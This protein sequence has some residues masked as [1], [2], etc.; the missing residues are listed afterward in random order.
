M[1][2][3]AAPL[4]CGGACGT[5]EGEPAAVLGVRSA[6]SAARSGRP[7]A[8]RG[9]GAPVRGDTSPGSRGTPPTAAPP[10]RPRHRETPGGHTAKHSFRNGPPHGRGKKSICLQ[11]ARIRRRLVPRFLQMLVPPYQA[12]GFS[13]YR[14]KLLTKE[15]TRNLW[16]KRADVQFVGSSIGSGKSTCLTP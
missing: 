1:G 4:T 11:Q 13:T 10:S 9:P 8:S 6:S 12:Y 16:D 2:R 5:R 15:L 7:A 3:V 14:E